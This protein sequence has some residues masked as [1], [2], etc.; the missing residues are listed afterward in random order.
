MLLSVWLA[1]Q[2]R[3]VKFN[4]W[5]RN[6]EKKKRFKVKMVAA[7]LG[8]NPRLPVNLLLH[9]HKSLHKGHEGERAPFTV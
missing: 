5:T 1:T 8:C 3:S 2:F 6:M 7:F 4:F 9:S